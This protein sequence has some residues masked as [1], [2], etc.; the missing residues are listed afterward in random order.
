MRLADLNLTI[1]SRDVELTRRALLTS[2]LCACS[3]LSLAAGPPTEEVLVI[4]VDPHY[5]PYSFYD[6]DQQL[7]GLN[8]SLARVA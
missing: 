7:T 6:A 8:P 3:G 2:L 1:F 5:P 4:G